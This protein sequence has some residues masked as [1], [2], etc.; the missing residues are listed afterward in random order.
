M[1]LI[2]SAFREV[3][4][5]CTRSHSRTGGSCELTKELQKRIDLTMMRQIEDNEP[6]CF[7]VFVDAQEW[8]E[9]N[10]RC[11]GIACTIFL[12]IYAPIHNILLSMSSRPHGDCF[13]CL[14][15]MSDGDGVTLLPCCSQCMHAI[16]LTQFLV[17]ARLNQ[18]QQQQLSASEAARYLCPACKQPL[19]L[20]D[21]VKS[22]VELAV[23]AA[24]KDATAAAHAEISSRAR[25][26]AEQREVAK[27]QRRKELLDRFSA[28]PKCCVCVLADRSQSTKYFMHAFGS[29]PCL[30]VIIIPF[31]P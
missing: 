19:V 4:L 25:R 11:A 6:V 7:R 14:C 18:L 31:S 27:A 26:D 30:S 1:R 28:A 9:E 22:A 8:L 2:W 10:N 23:S 13:V 16:C 20:E 3:F 21:D 5:R 29:S 12:L 24:I 15:D 17:S